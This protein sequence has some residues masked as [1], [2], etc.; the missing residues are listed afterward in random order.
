MDYISA[1]GVTVGLF[2]G[3]WVYL[4]GLVGLCGFAGFLGWAS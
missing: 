2:A 3:A 4:S 1:V